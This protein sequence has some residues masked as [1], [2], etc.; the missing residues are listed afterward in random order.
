VGRYSYA[1][2]SPVHLQDPTGLSSCDV[3]FCFDVGPGDMRPLD[4]RAIPRRDGH[5]LHNH[6]PGHRISPAQFPILV[7]SAGVLITDIVVTDTGWIERGLMMVD[8]ALAAPYAVEWVTEWDASA[9]SWRVT[10]RAFIEVNLPEAL[11]QEERATARDALRTVQEEW[12]TLS[13]VGSVDTRDG[14][15]AYSLNFD[16]R[17]FVHDVPTARSTSAGAPEAVTPGGAG[18]LPPFGADLDAASKTTKHGLFNR[19]LLPKATALD[20]NTL[21]PTTP[22]NNADVPGAMRFDSSRRG[23]STQS[24][25]GINGL[26]VPL[27]SNLL[28]HETGHHFG[29]PD[30]YGTSLAPRDNTTTMGTTG[31]GRIPVELFDERL[32]AILN[33]L[34]Y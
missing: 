31:L 15:Q 34:R 3:D 18:R 14:E 32:R 5:S 22:Y 24:F 10:V 26:S 8:G 21:R 28:R 30:Q 12:R 11:S 13:I 19:D 20:Q 23:R 17:L 25:V 9:D 27:L 4:G 33:L 2:G 16:L 29:L 6:A 1:K 7:A